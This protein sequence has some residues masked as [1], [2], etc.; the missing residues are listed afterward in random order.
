[1]LISYLSKG[2]AV[3]IIVMIHE[4]NSTVMKLIICE[5]IQECDKMNLNR[6]TFKD[7]EL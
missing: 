2:L 1:M 7:I 4:N 6:K 5:N 3:S